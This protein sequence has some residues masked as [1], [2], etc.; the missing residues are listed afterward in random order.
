M[1]L[2]K[3]NDSGCNL[4]DRFIAVPCD[5]LSSTGRDRGPEGKGMGIQLVGMVGVRRGQLRK[6]ASSLQKGG[7]D[8][9]NYVVLVYTK[10]IDDKSKPGAGRMRVGDYDG[11][12]IEGYGL[13]SGVW[14]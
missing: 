3:G 11:I 13:Y 6:V 10:W 7:E 1:T 2:C 8:G 12:G 4:R 5:K 9:V 14:G